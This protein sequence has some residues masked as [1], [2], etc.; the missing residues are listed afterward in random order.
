MKQTLN[1][2]EAE[3]NKAQPCTLKEARESLS[4]LVSKIN[5][6]IGQCKFVEKIKELISEGRTHEEIAQM[7]SYEQ[8]KKCSDLIFWNHV[9]I[10]KNFSLIS[11]VE[12]REYEQ[13]LEEPYWGLG[14]GYDMYDRNYISDLVVNK[15]IIG[16]RERPILL[17]QPG[18][19]YEGSDKDGLYWYTKEDVTYE[20]IF[21]HES[22]FLNFHKVYSE[23]LEH[24]MP[25]KQKQRDKPLNKF[26]LLD[27]AIINL[28]KEEKLTMQAKVFW[29]KLKR[30][31][32]SK[33]RE[34]FQSLVCEIQDDNKDDEKIL[35]V[36]PDN[37]KTK[38]YTFT[39]LTKKLAQYKTEVR[40]SKL[41]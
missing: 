37:N 18:T 21:F 23:E 24:Y 40:L 14:L 32:R 2:D 31:I 22:E 1:R 13:I 28:L 17:I 11:E 36:N 12:I 19:K 41:Q 16:N 10:W 9:Q 29:E 5:N 8:P 27:R 30:V 35:W 34:E 4:K 3:S 25:F 38:P 26:S 6:E 33:Q 15:K 39:T 7:F 20:D